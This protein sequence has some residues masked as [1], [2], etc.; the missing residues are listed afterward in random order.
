M[1]SWP[2]EPDG[3]IRAAVARGLMWNLQREYFAGSRER[4]RRLRD[5]CSAD[6]Q[7]RAW[8]EEYAAKPFPTEQTWR[9]AGFRRLRDLLQ[10]RGAT[11]V[12]QVACSSGREL[13]WFAQEHPGAHFVGSDIDAGVVE[14]CRGRWQLPNLEFEVL[15]VDEMREAPK[16]DVVLS[17]GGLQYVDPEGLLGFFQRLG[18]TVRELILVEPLYVGFDPDSARSMPRENLSWNHPYVTLLRDTG[19]EVSWQEEH[20][21]RPP[22]WVKNI[23]VIARRTGSA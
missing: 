12:H 7:L 11:S 5:E 9:H 23:S 15:A 21:D 17:S 18:D 4:R 20:G 6:G 8:A 1:R 3:K 19:W 10:T 22:V 16:A 2:S 14:F 13:A